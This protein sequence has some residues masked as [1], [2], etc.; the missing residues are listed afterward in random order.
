MNAASINYT[1]SANQRSS[2]ADMVNAIVR[3]NMTTRTFQDMS[4]FERQLK[5]L[6]YRIMDL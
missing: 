3:V 1:Y 6:R 4:A 5:D 2:M